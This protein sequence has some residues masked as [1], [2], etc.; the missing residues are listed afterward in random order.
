MTIPPI[1]PFHPEPYSAL[2]NPA[3]AEQSR[4]LKAAAELSRNQARGVNPFVKTRNG[5]H[6]I[7][8]EL[9]TAQIYRLIRR[10]SMGSL[11]FEQL[12]TIPLSQLSQEEKNFILFLKRNK[13]VF[14]RI[15]ALDHKPDS[16]SVDD[17][18]IAAQLAGNALVLSED[19]LKYLKQLPEPKLDA[20]PSVGT[21]STLQTNANVSTASILKL[22]NKINPD[23]VDESTLVNAPES[24]PHLTKADLEALKFLKQPTVSHLLDRL[25]PHGAKLTPDHV[26]MMM[27][28]LFAP[29]MYGTAP[30][31]FI[32][33]PAEI[34]EDVPVITDPEAVEP[35]HTYHVPIQTN[36]YHSH[37]RLSAHELMALCHAISP[38]GHVTLQQLRAYKP[39][40][41]KEEKMLQTLKNAGIFQA[42]AHLD[43]DDDD[44]SDDD[45]RI[46]L[47]DGSLVLSDPHITLVILP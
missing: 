7:H 36:I 27:S 40:T 26:A 13:A 18:K 15:A 16:L 9:N 41:D 14:Q 3:L 45:I 28:L 19:D 32:K 10:Y 17:V 38:N 1:D 6:D 12:N 8:F 39:R 11:T 34:D 22:L 46:A 21:P 47:S 44:L 29:A 42:L 43:H 33:P 2:P 25:V 4:L 37:I 20:K 35:V 24:N 30:I 5:H 23:G 31:L